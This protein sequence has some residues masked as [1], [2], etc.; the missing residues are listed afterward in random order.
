MDYILKPVK[1]EALVHAIKRA[2]ERIH[3]DVAINISKLLTDL[4]MGYMHNRKIPLPSSEGI[5]FIEDTDIIRCEA[6]GRYTILYF[7]NRKK[8]T[9]TKTLKEMEAL[10]LPGHFFRVH[11]SH[12]INL[13]YIKRYIKGDGGQIEMQN[14]TFVTVARRKK[15]EFLKAI[16]H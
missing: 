10:L 8:L 16:G 4:K 13:H 11:H 3:Q 2:E 9:V 6:N 15:D 5:L 7:V 14:G 12:I 1:T